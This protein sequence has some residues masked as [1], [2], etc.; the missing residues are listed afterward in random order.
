MSQ[1]DEITHTRIPRLTHKRIPRHADES[2]FQ[3]QMC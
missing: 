2:K 3:Q 1:C